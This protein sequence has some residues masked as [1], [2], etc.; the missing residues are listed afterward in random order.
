MVMYDFNIFYIILNYNL[1]INIYVI[2]D[3]LF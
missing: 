1:W 3:K 2:Y